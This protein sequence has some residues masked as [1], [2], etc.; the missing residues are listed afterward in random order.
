MRFVRA[1]AAGAAFFALCCLVNGWGLPSA[2]RASYF[3]PVPAAREA[4][5]GPEAA[6]A[7]GPAAS[8]HPGETAI[9]A[10][11]A[12]MRPG[13][14]DFNPHLFTVPS[15][16]LYA[17]GAALSQ[18]QRHR[19][20]PGSRNVED[21]AQHP[22]DAARLYRFGRLVSAL[23]AALLILTLC[24]LPGGGPAAAL[25]L[26][27]TPIFLVGATNL[28]GDL[29]G[30]FLGTL[31]V[32]AAG[33][34][35][36]PGRGRALALG[37]L[38]GL[39]TSAAYAAVLAFVPLAFA[40]AGP[41]RKGGGRLGVLG[42]A[43]I[44]GLLGFLAGTPYAL[45][46]PLEF[47][48]GLRAAFAARLPN[49]LGAVAHAWPGWSHQLRLTF[50]GGCGLPFTVFLAGIPGCLLDLNPR[51][52]ALLLYL[53]AWAVLVVPGVAPFAGQVLTALP[54]AALLAAEG[55]WLILE[56]ARLERGWPALAA[57]A[58]PALPQLAVALAYVLLMVGPD[59]RLL[60]ARAVTAW[61]GGTHIRLLRPPGFTTP[62]VDPGRYQLDVGPVSA[63]TL[64][65][66]CPQ[67]LVASEFELLETARSA[68][69]DPG[70]AAL[71]ASL[72]HPADTLRVGREAWVAQEIRR[73]AGLGAWVLPTRGEPRALVML[74]PTI[75]LWRRI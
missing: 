59:T 34:A 64:R 47:A 19:W 7:G 20:A 15:L 6:L 18:A 31:A 17:V 10:A 43:L 50:V 60:A 39:A 37:L 69:A 62:P 4:A 12:G 25:M 36:S 68:P 23:W 58:L 51:R 56:R 32:L 24:L 52:Q 63:D 5:A 28:T 55:W 49:A 1:F 72:L 75:L 22:E 65:A 44:G 54:V 16:Q 40:C 61:P 30:A 66:L 74:H 26:A 29:A 53:L 3:P 71:S 48:G 14:R 11:L 13:R 70:C 42:L 73:P 21:Y 45:L 67:T 9:L 35:R 38:A 27:A 57:L 8:V 41:S 33:A 2:E 46:A